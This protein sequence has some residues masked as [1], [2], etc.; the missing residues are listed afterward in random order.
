MNSKYKGLWKYALQQEWPAL[1]RIFL[2]SIFVSVFQLSLPLGI[3]SLTIFISGGEFTF[4]LI[5]IV[6]I[7]IIATFL[8][9]RW[10]IALLKEGEDIELRWFKKLSLAY[11]QKWKQQKDPAEQALYQE[12]SKYFIEISSI[13]KG[14]SK[15][16]LEW[17][18]AALQL[19]LGLVL[20]SFYHTFFLIFGVLL[21]A[22]LMILIR[23]KGRASIITKMDLSNA[24]YEMYQ[25]LQDGSLNAEE[26]QQKNQEYKESKETHFHTVLFQVQYFL[27]IKI[28]VIAGMLVLGTWLAIEQQISIGQFL[29]AEIV[30]VLIVNSLEK[31][32][33]SIASV[34]EN[35]V[36]FE[37][38]LS[39]FHKEF[40][41]PQIDQE[42]DSPWLIEKET[43]FWNKQKKLTAALLIFIGILLLPWTQNIESEGKVISLSPNERPQS[44]QSIIAGR[45]EKWFVQEG[46][47]VIAGDTLLFISEIKDEYFDPQLLANTESQL[48][49]KENAV[50]SYMEKVQAL[51]HQIDA[52]ITAKEI[53]R[54]QTKTKIDQARLKVKTDSVEYLTVEK[55]AKIIEEQLNRYQSLLEQNVISRTEWETRQMAYQNA[56]AK[57]NDQYNKLNIARAEWENA[58]REYRGI[59]AE[60][61]DKIAK[62]ESDKHSTFSAMYDTEAQVTKLQNQYNNYDKRSGLY[63]I[64]APQNGFVSKVTKSGIGETI[65]EGEEVVRIS[66]QNFKT[67]VELWISPVNNPLVHEGENVRI[68]FDGW[69]A[70]VVSGWSQMSS[71]LFDGVITSVDPAIQENGKF[72]IWVTPMEGH[73]WPGQLRMGGGAKGILL[74]NDV[75]LVYELWR[76]LNGF[77]PDFYT[78]EKKT[79]ETTKK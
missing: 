49:S 51:D 71:G 77:S 21:L 3:Q 44:V 59:E 41:L 4:G 79:I 66:P 23:I 2:L 60:Y 40:T 27:I 1:K 48:V 17:M 65:K 10:Q 56:Q 34:Y 38:A 61:R 64:I 43:T 36:S 55:N 32:I 29:A 31:I 46:D 45:I 52:L 50:N 37:K 53:K 70:F 16:L 14:F 58:V 54:Q 69:P 72:R 67:A 11:F 20:I 42:K 5:S 76:I 22:T 62:A 26:I 12:K 33:T 15:R 18:G 57:K 75:P 8:A 19:V 28:A 63:Y 24:K 30:I 39:L 78:P 9:N 73:Q 6:I 74:L 47:S 13:Q 7:V 35:I 68:I 25:Y